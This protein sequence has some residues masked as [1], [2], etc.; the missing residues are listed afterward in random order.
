VLQSSDALVHAAAQRVHDLLEL[1]AAEIR[2]AAHSG[3]A[4]L[5][6]VMIMSAALVVAW[7]LV[8]ACAL[9]LFSRTSIGWPLPAL[10]IAAG[11]VALAY[12]LW[13]VTVGL[14]ANLTLPDLRRT[15]FGAEASGEET[16]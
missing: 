10:V 9:Y 2:L 15:A 5:L 3:L 12:Y 4:M 14:S 13:Q 16:R 7:A 6:L 11:H 1:A 8:V